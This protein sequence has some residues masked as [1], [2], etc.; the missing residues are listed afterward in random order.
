MKTREWLGALRERNFALYFIGQTT[1]GIGSGMA[2]VAIT[3]AVLDRGT[4]TDVGLVSAAGML[5]L[6]VFLLIG[7]VFADRFSR[8]VVM[9]GSDLVRT[10][11]EI[12]LGIWI[13]CTPPPLW[14]FMA[15][16]AVVG[17]GSAFFSPASTGLVPSVI[18]PGNLQQANALNTLSAS[19]SGIIG[20][21][22]AGV[23]VAAANPGWAVLIDGMTYLVSVASLWL[24]KIEW[25]GTLTTTSMWHELR[26]GWSE[27]WSR[28]WLWVIVVEFS[29]VNI[30]IFAPMMVM[31]PGIAKQS[32]GGAAVWGL[33]LAVEGAGAVTGGVLMLRWKPRRPLLVATA[34]TLVWVWPLIGLATLAP[35]WVIASGA[36]AGGSM[37]SI[38]GT[39]WNTTMQ[40][41][42]PS[43]ILSRVSAYDWFGSL[44]FLPVGLAL[45]GPVQHA[46][47]TRTSI[48]GCVILILMMVG[49]ALCVPSIQ[50]MRTPEDTPA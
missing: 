42:I 34:S 14:G 3:F 21:A 11:A 31:G 12:A 13:L 50:S 36:F 47:G 33:V 43:E 22:A 5:P 39:I 40:R 41:E 35:V 16:A 8:R 32:L 45:V 4:T 49:A 7:G 29:V 44:V 27:F 48:V 1:S 9:L 19:M 10:A 37:M 17:F 24:I 20:P 25:S 28:T 2:P 30:L 23:I 15:L 18:S 6:V 38:F 26:E 46:L